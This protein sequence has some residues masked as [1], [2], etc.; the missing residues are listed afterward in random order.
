MLKIGEFSKTVGMTVKALRHYEN[1]GLIQPYWIDKYTGYRY[2]E[3][4]QVRLVRQ[5]AYLKCLGFSLKE[6]QRLVSDDLTETE[7]L[8]IFE[9]KLHDINV[10]LEQAKWRLSALE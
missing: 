4:S 2:Y 1:L 6:V 7:R 5:I 8:R 9:N 10:Q 3:E